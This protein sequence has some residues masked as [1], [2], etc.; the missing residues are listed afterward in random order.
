[1]ALLVNAGHAHPAALGIEEVDRLRDALV[2]SVVA[3][4]ERRG[5]NA[6]GGDRVTTRRAQ[7]G[8]I[9]YIERA[10]PRRLRRYL[11]AQHHLRCPRAHHPKFC[12]AEPARNRRL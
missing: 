7:L 9:E 5:A 6:T 2:P 11:L 1:M 3:D 8:E 4:A 12:G 10:Q